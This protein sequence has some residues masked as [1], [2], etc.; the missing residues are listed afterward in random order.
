MNIWIPALS[1]AASSLLFTA[2]CGE[3][4]E[5]TVTGSCNIDSAPLGDSEDLTFQIC[6]DFADY[7]ESDEGAT[8][9]E[10]E[11]G[12]GDSEGTLPVGLWSDSGCDTSAATASCS[13]NDE[14]GTSTVYVYHSGLNEILN[15]VDEE[16]D[17]LC[18]AGTYNE[19]VPDVPKQGAFTVTIGEAKQ[20]CS[21][22]L[23]NSYFYDFYKAQ[24]T[25]N[26]GSSSVTLDWV[27]DGTCTTTGMVGKCVAATEGIIAG[28]T[29]I[30]YTSSS[31]NETSCTSEGG[32][33][34]T[35]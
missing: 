15:Q 30:H 1:L 12:I 18:S 31:S 23:I 2:S 3:E 35:N 9:A 11:S 16:S 29:R 7:E 19:L 17:S 22:L 6:F 5:K 33:W 4:D 21:E 27:D 25:Q 26:P 24:V 32:T 13:K 8:K 20:Y 14:G 10:C 28:E 34:S